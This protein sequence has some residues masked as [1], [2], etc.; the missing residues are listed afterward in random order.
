MTERNVMSNRPVNSHKIATA[1]LKNYDFRSSAG[2]FSAATDKQLSVGMVDNCFDHNIFSCILHYCLMIYRFIL[3]KVWLFSF[4][5][6]FYFGVPIVV[7]QSRK[8][9]W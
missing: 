8:E 1:S 4:F 9:D 3:L 6:S 2:N 5:L 7:L